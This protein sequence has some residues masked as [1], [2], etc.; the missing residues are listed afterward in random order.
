MAKEKTEEQQEELQ[1]KVV[2]VNR[3][4]KV[5]KGGRQFSFSAI[6]VV[7]DTKGTLGWGYGKAKEVAEAIRKASSNARKNMFTVSMYKTTIPHQI[8]GKYKAGKVMLKPAPEGT[9]I[10]AGGAVRA[11]C[12]TAGIKDIVTKCLNTTNPINVIKACEVGLKNLKPRDY[13]QQLKGKK[14]KKSKV[15]NDENK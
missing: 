9:G 2:F 15:T 8:M 7:G 4:A 5:L 6:V 12:E 3:V 13:R 10:I 1:E 14:K 11:M